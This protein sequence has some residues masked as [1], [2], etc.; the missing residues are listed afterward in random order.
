MFNTRKSKNHQKLFVENLIEEMEQKVAVMLMGMSQDTYLIEDVMLS[1]WTLLCQKV[2]FV[3]THKNPQ[4]WVMNVAKYQMYQALKSRQNVDVYENFMIESLEGYIQEE[5]NRQSEWIETLKL[6][7]PQK[8]YEPIILKY[9]YDVSYVE[10]ADYYQCSEATI[11]KRVSR[12]MKK[13]RRLGKDLW[14]D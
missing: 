9:F 8:E 12:G 10:L 13:L 3:M 14:N 4:G 1:T 6:H 7:L 2:E 5:Q 11:R